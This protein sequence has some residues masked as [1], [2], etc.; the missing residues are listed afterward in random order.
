MAAAPAWE[1][2]G[3]VGGGAEVGWRGRAC[4]T[5]GPG[6]TAWTSW[7][8][9]REAHAQTDTGNLTMPAWVVG[10]GGRPSS[11]SS[12]AATSTNT[13]TSSRQQGA[14]AS[15]GAGA[16]AGARRGTRGRA[17]PG[18]QERSNGMGDGSAGR[19]EGLP[20]PPL[21]PCFWGRVGPGGSWWRDSP[22][23]THRRMCLE[24]WGLTVPG[25]GG[26]ASPQAGLAPGP[27]RRVDG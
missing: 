1:T 25:E 19:T 17:Q 20:L 21:L 26:W 22:R 14:G 6:R 8:L 4:P 10:S 15:A 23:T 13:S 16:G 27:G 9:G 18:H 3:H 2:R 5:V 7:L 12:T 24:G 11:G